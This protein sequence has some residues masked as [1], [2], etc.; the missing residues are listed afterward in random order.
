M[1]SSLNSSGMVLMDSMSSEVQ[2]RSA[3][4]VTPAF[5][6]VPTGRALGA[7]I[8]GID[9]RVLRPDEVR[10][11]RGAWNEHQVLLFREQ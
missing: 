2:G 5:D 6:I 9:L 8:R 4:S 1:A 10:A 11:V 7:E 3:R